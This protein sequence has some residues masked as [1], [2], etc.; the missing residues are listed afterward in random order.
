MSSYHELGGVA[1]LLG[2]EGAERINAAS[3]LGRTDLIPYFRALAYE[4]VTLMQN[5]I[6]GTVNWGTGEIQYGTGAASGTTA[7]WVSGTAGGNYAQ[8]LRAA[9]DWYISGRFRLVTTP[10][11]GTVLGIGGVDASF[12]NILRVGANFADNASFFCVRGSAGAPVVSAVPFD[13]VMHVFR[14]WRT[15]GVTFFQIDGGAVV[16]GTANL[17]SNIAACLIAINGTAADQRAGV[18]WL[19][20][21]T[22]PA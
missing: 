2:P 6:A 18:E 19:F 14:A 8:A 12:A 1:G 15:G 9:A 7:A 11:T 3:L 13:T 22:P 10:T 20:V 4:G 5:V 21:A 16:S 17:T